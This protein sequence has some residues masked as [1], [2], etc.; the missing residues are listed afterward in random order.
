[1]EDILR[2]KC[3]FQVWISHVLHFISICELFTGSPSYKT[4]TGKHEGHKNFRAPSASLR[5][6][7]GRPTAAGEYFMTLPGVCRDDR[8][9]TVLNP[10]RQCTNRIR[11]ACWR[12]QACL[13][14]RR[15]RRIKRCF[16]EL[17]L[18]W[19]TLQHDRSSSVRFC[20]EAADSNKL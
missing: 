7:L 11:G 13:K 1:M 4:Y 5:H 19:R 8:K 10:R 15:G 18:S 14:V 17:P 3:F 2:N 9:M 16:V 12:K 6:D 20:I